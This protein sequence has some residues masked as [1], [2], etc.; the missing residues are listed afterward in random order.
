[1][2]LET[3]K[4]GKSRVDDIPG[5]EVWKWGINFSLRSKI[6]SEKIEDFHPTQGVY[7]NDSRLFS[8]SYPLTAIHVSHKVH[9]GN[10]NT[11][12]LFCINTFY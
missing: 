3:Y 1:M 5:L 8:I 2:A 4:C 7:V 9:Q 11:G 12:K 6:E 10:L